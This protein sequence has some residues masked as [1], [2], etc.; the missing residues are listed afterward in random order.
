MRLYLYYFDQKEG[1]V[2]ESYMDSDEVYQYLYQ[3]NML[4]LASSQLWRKYDYI[5]PSKYH[6]G[7]KFKLDTRDSKPLPEEKYAKL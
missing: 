4:Q 7:D 2:I 6:D 1:D 3:M 5:N